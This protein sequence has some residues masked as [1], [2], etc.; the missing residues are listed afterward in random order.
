MNAMTL[1]ITVMEKMMT[2][3]IGDKKDMTK[4]AWREKQKIQRVTNDFNTG[5]RTLKSKKDYKR[6]WRIEDYD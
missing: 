3:R 6:K 1:I 2:M 4:K 5:T